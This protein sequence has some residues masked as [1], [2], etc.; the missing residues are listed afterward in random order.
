MWKEKESNNQLSPR[1][2]LNILQR[3]HQTMLRKDTPYVRYTN[4]CR[5]QYE[6]GVYWCKHV[7][8][9][10]EDVEDVYKQQME[11]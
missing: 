6:A 10:E 4:H 9:P 7:E 2:V 3:L 5:W 8:I 1:M 11:K